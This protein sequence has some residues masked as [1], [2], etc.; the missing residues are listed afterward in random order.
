MATVTGTGRFGLSVRK[1]PGLS[2]ERVATVPDGFQAAVVSGPV[3]KDGADWYQVRAPDV[4]GWASGAYLSIGAGAAPSLPPP[5]VVTKPAASNLPNALATPLSG[6]LSQV[7]RESNYTVN[8]SGI[9][10][11]ERLKPAVDHLSDSKTAIGLLRRVAPAYLRLTVAHFPASSEGGEFSTLGHSIKIADSILQE[12]L[13]VQATVIGHELQHASDI[14][15]DHAAPDTA[16]EC[17]NLEVRAFRTQE[18]VW[19]EITKP[20]PP[21]TRMERELDQLAHLVDTPA[22]AQQLAKQ[23]ANECATYAGSS[24]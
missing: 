21:K 19:L 23:Y 12:G 14:L 20:S 17:I 6:L 8:G 22:F 13:E 3:P 2:A 10:V 7:S 16:Q 4:T 5:D 1:E 9:F 11:E 15:I 18:T 24:R